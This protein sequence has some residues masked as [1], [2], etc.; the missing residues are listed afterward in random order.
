[1]FLNLGNPRDGHWVYVVLDVKAKQLHLVDSMAIGTHEIA[2]K[3][4][5][6]SVGFLNRLFEVSEARVWSARPPFARRES[7]RDW[8]CKLTLL[9][10]HLH[11]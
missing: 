5:R 10:V 11:R 8:T 9:G 6:R 1:M 2:L 4:L 7:L 3:L